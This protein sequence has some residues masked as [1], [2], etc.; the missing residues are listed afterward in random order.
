[1]TQCPYCARQFEEEG[2]SRPLTTVAINIRARVAPGDVVFRSHITDMVQ[3]AILEWLHENT[4]E[5][6]ESTDE[7]VDLVDVVIAR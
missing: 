1:M 6:I 4:Y 2:E 7:M 3:A 5:T